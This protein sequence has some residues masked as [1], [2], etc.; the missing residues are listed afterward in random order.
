MEV[1]ECKKWQIKV[2]RKG[3]REGGWRRWGGGVVRE[4]AEEEKV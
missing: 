1:E 4:R 2:S 3:V